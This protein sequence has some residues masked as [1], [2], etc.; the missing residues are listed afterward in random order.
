MIDNK[1]FFSNK[2]TIENNFGKDKFSFA[3]SVNINFFYNLK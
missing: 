2:I 3:E 1:I